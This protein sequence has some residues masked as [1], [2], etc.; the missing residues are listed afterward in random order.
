[1]GPNYPDKERHDEVSFHGNV[2][3][4]MAVYGTYGSFALVNGNLS[5]G[6]KEYG[7]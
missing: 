6:I 7:A 4:F 3:Q 5:Y 1:M 2:V